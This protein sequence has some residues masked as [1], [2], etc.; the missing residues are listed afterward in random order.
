MP[1]L[2]ILSQSRDWTDK[3][4]DFAALA[5]LWSLLFRWK[6]RMWI[7]WDS[8]SDRSARVCNAQRGNFRFHFRLN[9]W[10]QPSRRVRCKDKI[11]DLRS[12]EPLWSRTRHLHYHVRWVPVLDFHTKLSSSVIFWGDKSDWDCLQH[13]GYNFA[14]RILRL[15]WGPGLQLSGDSHTHQL[16]GFCDSQWIVKRLHDCPNTRFK[17]AG[18]VHGDNKIRDM[19]ARR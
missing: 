11:R 12:S 15:R 14:S 6:A 7:P 1:G 16:A 17:P 4:S 10:L 9:Y 18:V 19:L 13:W 2:R 3:S 5:D 8:H